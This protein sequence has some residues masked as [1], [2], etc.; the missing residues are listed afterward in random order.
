VLAL[1]DQDFHTA[2]RPVPG[3]ANYVDRGEWTVGPELGWVLRPNFFLVAAIRGGLQHQADLLGVPLNSS[4]SLVRGLVGLEGQP[5]P[6]W[7]FSL[8]AG[9]DVRRFGSKAPPGLDREQTT[10]Y[11]EASATWSPTASDTLTLGS[12]R[13]L[14]VSSGG[15]TVYED[16]LHDLSWKHQIAPAWSVTTSVNLHT[17]DNRGYRPAVARDDVIRGGA[18]LFSRGLGPQARLEFGAALDWS[19]SGVPSTR[20]REYHRRQYSLSYYCRW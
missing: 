20:G 10:P 12:R 19:R 17:A 16:G 15:R 8:L 14:W 13:Q 18:V 4:S 9:P 2:E 6:A 5:T 3:Y 1:G 11:W 7:K